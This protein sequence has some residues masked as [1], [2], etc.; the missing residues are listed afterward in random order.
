MSDLDIVYILL[1]GQAI[2]MFA[3]TTWYYRRRVKIEEARSAALKKQGE[4]M[5]AY[6]DARLSVE[7]AKLH[8]EQQKLASRSDILLKK[9]GLEKEIVNHPDPDTVVPLSP[10][11]TKPGA[12]KESEA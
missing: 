12:I 10:T 6:Y 2:G 3:L 4:Q 11:V 1:A 8:V 7:K 5:Y 9:G